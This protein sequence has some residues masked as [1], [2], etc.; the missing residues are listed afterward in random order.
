MALCPAPFTEVLQRGKLQVGFCFVFFYATENLHT[1]P[2]STSRV[3][4]ISGTSATGRQTVLSL[5]ARD[6]LR[7]PRAPSSS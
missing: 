3:T 2:S 1:H 4:A 6:L 5:H 7:V